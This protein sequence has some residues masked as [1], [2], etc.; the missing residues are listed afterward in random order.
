M[1][2]LLAKVFMVFLLVGA[3]TGQKVIINC[4]PPKTPVLK[5]VGECTLGEGGDKVTL[6]WTQENR[7]EVIRFELEKFI[8]G[9][10]KEI[11]EPGKNASTYIDTNVLEGVEYYYRLRA[12]N[13]WQKGDWDDTRATVPVCKEPPRSEDCE[14]DVDTVVEYFNAHVLQYINEDGKLMYYV[15]LVIE[16]NGGSRD[17]YWELLRSQYKVKELEK[18][19]SYHKPFKKKPGAVFRGGQ[20]E[21]YFEDY[22]V[23]RHKEFHYILRWNCGPCRDWEYFGAVKVRIPKK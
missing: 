8:S 3:L 2:K 19:E 5:S 21:Y 7:S 20:S 9:S 22:A 6:T 23:S 4:H 16:V 14:I 17:G 15:Q 10:W 11:A 12:V 1:K 13:Q 18:W